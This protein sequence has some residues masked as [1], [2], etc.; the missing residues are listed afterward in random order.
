MF[1]NWYSFL[2]KIKP[3]EWLEYGVVL[4]FVMFLITRIV[5]PSALQIIG[6]I[7]AI[8]VIYYRIDKRTTIIQDSYD[9]LEFRLKTLFPKPQNF[10]MDADIINVFY[11][12]RDMRK[13]HSESYDTSLVAV[14]NMLKIVSEMQGGVYHCKENLDIVRNQMGKALNGLQT[15]IYKL[16]ANLV[17][18][19]KLKR[20]L[21]GLQV[22]L[23]R[24]VDDMVE[25]CKKQ[26]KE[27][28]MDIDYHPIYNKGPRAD[29]TKR[30]EF[31]QYDFY[32]TQ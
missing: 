16:P 6:L 14:D 18:Q 7:I 20:A 15:M 23:R 21:N 10:H 4:V 32:Y 26:Y 5:Q 8:I 19:R 17:Y 27:R 28:G 2:N 11:N 22:I 12:I 24:H 13:F 3:N 1:G 29:D 25:L 31:S 9:E 30:Q